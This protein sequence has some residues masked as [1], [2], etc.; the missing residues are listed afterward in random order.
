MPEKKKVLVIGGGISGL[1]AAYYIR[2]FCR[3]QNVPLELTLLEKSD[4]L[5]G[6]IQTAHREGFIIERGPDSFLSRKLPIIE[7]SEALGLD[8]EW[9]PTNPEANRTFIV[10][11]GKLHRFPSGFMLGIPTQ[12]RAL[13]NTGLISPLGKARAI[14]DLLLP[15]RRTTEDESLGRFLERRL[16]QEVVAHIAEPLLS[17]IYAGDAYALSLQATFPQFQALEQKKRSLILGMKA[18]RQDTHASSRLPEIA[19]K[20]AFLSFRQGLGALVDRLKATLE[21]EADIRLNQNVKKIEKNEGEDTYTLSVRHNAQGQTQQD[22]FEADSIILATPAYVTAKL[23]PDLSAADILAEMPYVSVAN[24]VLAFDARHIP[25]SFDGSGFVVPRKEKRSITACT[26]TSSKWMHVAPE[27]KVL[28]RAYVGHAGNEDI[29]Q[30]EDREILD[31]VLTDLREL[32]GL[33]ASPLFYEINRWPQAMPQYPVG[34]LQNLKRVNDE[35]NNQFPGIYLC[36]AGYRGVGIP[37][38]I[39]QGKEAAEQVITYLTTHQ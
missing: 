2:Q 20:S 3:E 30:L 15:R 13:V 37:D 19:K 29:V 36:G 26:W 10:H 28:L 1:S 8:E 31:Q 33:Q 34:H 12:L 16:G 22:V 35:L 4:A 18:T 9:V 11:N 25:E 23:L 7:L 32:T 5:G 14:L 17:G 39:R 24:V 27:G 6:K 21:K 38:C